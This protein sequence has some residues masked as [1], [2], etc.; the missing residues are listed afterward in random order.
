MFYLSA[1]HLNNSDKWSL[2]KI[3]CLASY[4]EKISIEHG[5]KIFF[6][7][8]N[9]T[10]Y[11]QLTITA[12][13]LT[14]I[15]FA[16]VSDETYNQ[17]RTREDTKDLLNEQSMKDIISSSEKNEYQELELNPDKRIARASQDA[18]RLIVYSSSGSTGKPKLIPMKSSQLW[19]C[20]KYILDKHIIKPEAI[21][22]TS[23]LLNPHKTSFVITLNYI[24]FGLILMKPIICV[25][26]ANIIKLTAIVRNHGEK[27]FLITVPT[28]LNAI[29]KY[30]ESTNGSR[31]KIP[32]VISC[33]ESLRTSVASKVGEWSES[34]YNFYGASEFCTWI[35]SVNVD[36][37]LIARQN[38]INSPYIPV[39]N[40]FPV[41]KYTFYPDNSNELY[42][43]SPFMVDE[44]IDY[45]FKPVKMKSIVHEEGTFISVGDL[46]KCNEGFLLPAGRTNSIVK[47]RGVFFDLYKVDSFL[48]SRLENITFLVTASQT[49]VVVY[50]DAKSLSKDQIDQ[51]EALGNSPKL[52][53]V[54]GT[55]PICINLEKAGLRYNASNKLDRKF[56]GEHAAE[57]F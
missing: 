24:F 6:V 38:A 25:L 46:F 51:L 9:N 19:D 57:Y 34:L 40:F 47:I 22:K 20:H 37:N 43:D 32:L 55:I 2:S 27:A 23:Y 42:I 14:N 48:S 44:Y 17:M 35:S 49:A 21:A 28:L 53:E 31:V 33:G 10:F 15:S 54:L 41:V 7:T 18:D 13:I 39:G 36:A 4:F 29:A 16:V 8:E 52:K 1:S 50:I 11:S 26:P 56:Y 12:L 3:S 45:K 30:L 5:I